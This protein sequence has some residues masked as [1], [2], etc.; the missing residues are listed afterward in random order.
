[1]TIAAWRASTYYVGLQPALTAT[2]Y[3]ILE[4][5][6]TPDGN[7][8][9]RH[10]GSLTHYVDGMECSCIDCGRTYHAEDGLPLLWSGRYLAGGTW[11]SARCRE[12]WAVAAGEVCV[13]CGINRPTE[14]GP[15]G[16]RCGCLATPVT[17]AGDD[18]AA[19]SIVA[20]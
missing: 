15:D 3:D 16:G 5:R 20:A 19:G 17:T 7:T 4:L 11:C 14:V 8:V 2:G 18:V 1:M 12:R 9:A 10:V 13:D 6:N